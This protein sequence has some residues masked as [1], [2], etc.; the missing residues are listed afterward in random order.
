M[1]EELWRTMFEALKVQSE[2]QF[3][4]LKKSSQSVLEMAQGPQK[5]AA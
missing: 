3:A 4:E 1:L 2:A 5:A